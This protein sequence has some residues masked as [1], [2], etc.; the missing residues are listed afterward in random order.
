MSRIFTIE[1]QT[2]HTASLRVRITRVDT[3]QFVEAKRVFADAVTAASEAHGVAEDWDSTGTAGVYEAV[4]SSD[5]DREGVF[6]AAQALAV[7][8][9]ASDVFAAP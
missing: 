2:L 3:F 9:S 5:V 6:A 4:F 7:S 8:L 1:T